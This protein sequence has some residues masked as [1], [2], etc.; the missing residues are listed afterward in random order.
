MPNLFWVF[1][2]CVACLF[3]F[4]FLQPLSL[5]PSSRR[6]LRFFFGWT[7]SWI[8]TRHWVTGSAHHIHIHIAASARWRLWRQWRRVNGLC[9]L[10][11]CCC[12][13]QQHPPHRRPAPPPFSPQRIT[14]NRSRVNNVWA[15][16][17][18]GQGF[19]YLHCFAEKVLRNVAG[20]FKLWEFGVCNFTYYCINFHWKFSPFSATIYAAAWK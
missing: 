14:T 9:R 18:S 10:V 2:R 20:E 6:T 4:H 8:R 7:S 15:A 3:A 13:A 17:E 1:S 19:F 5:R 12:C 16:P 11:T